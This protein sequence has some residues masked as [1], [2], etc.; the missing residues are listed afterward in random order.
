MAKLAWPG[1]Q[2]KRNCRSLSPC[3]CS[4]FAFLKIVTAVHLD[5]WFVFKCL[6]QYVCTEV[7]RCKHAQ[8][9]LS[10]YFIYRFIG[11]ANFAQI[12]LPQGR[13]MVHRL[14]LV[15]QV[16]LFLQNFCRIPTFR[17]SCVIFQFC[18][19]YR[20]WWWDDQFFQ[21]RGVDGSPGIPEWECFPHL[22]DW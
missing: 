12:L 3:C 15:K 10:C 16:V 20:F 1:N 21:W 4:L 18:L 17:Y 8:F 2:G 5:N 19:R 6:I 14:W 13:Q 7:C 11:S 9:Q 22:C